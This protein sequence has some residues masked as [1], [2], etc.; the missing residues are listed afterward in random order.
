M[1]S[2]VAALP[3]IIF[4][5]VKNNKWTCAKSLSIKPGKE[6]PHVKANQNYKYH[7]KARILTLSSEWTGFGTEFVLLTWSDFERVVHYSDMARSVGH[8]NWISEGLQQDD[9]KIA[10]VLTDIFGSVDR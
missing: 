3:Y 10:R 1:T 8:V 2:A 6:L 4:Q 5:H 7:L 9:L